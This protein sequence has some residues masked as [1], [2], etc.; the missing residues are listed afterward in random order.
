M[1]GTDDLTLPDGWRNPHVSLAG[2]D[3]NAFAIVTKVQ[4]GLRRAG[5]PPEVLRA[6]RKAAMSGDYNHLLYVSC[7]YA[8]M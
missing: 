8:G 6:Y 1:A 3:G 7:L 4:A 2:V 5:N